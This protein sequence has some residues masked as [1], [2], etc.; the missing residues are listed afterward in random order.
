MTE[1][2]TA[3]RA[4]L[5][6]LGQLRA[7]D[8]PATGGR[9]LAY[10]YDSGLPELDELAAQAMRLVQPVNGLDPTAFPSVATME[11]EVLSFARDTFHGG[12]DVQG[13]VTSG[14][15]ESCLLAV[16]T[17]RDAWRAERERAGQ[18]VE[19]TPRLVLPVTAHAAFQKAAHLFG[20]RL[21]PVPVG[22][23]GQVQARAMIDRL[24]ADVALVVV[25]APSYPT[26]QLDPIRSV[27]AAAKE[28]GIACHVDACI[29]GFALAWWPGL[30]D[31]D[32]RV[33]GVTSLSADLHKYGY[34]PK[35]ASVLLQ[36]GRS[37]HRRQFF[38]TVRWPG[39]P[40][41][42]P[43]LLG[44]KSAAAL[45]AAW[46]ITQRLDADGFR[47]LTAQAQRATEAI[48]HEIGTIAGLRVLGDPTGPLF[49]LVTDTDV[50]VTDRVDPHLLAD[51]MR[52]LGFQ[53]QPQ[54]G[55]AQ[56][57]GVR[58]PHSVH[59]TVT[60]VTESILP[61]FLAVL[62]Q[63]AEDVRGRP[64]PEPRLALAGLR[65]LGLLRPGARLSPDTAWRLLRLMGAGGASGP[66]EM[67]PLLAIV[68]RLPPEVA[69]TILTELIARL[70]QPR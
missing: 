15:T 48:R 69:E 5:D 24:G 3:S 55:L 36:R 26:A 57:S 12:R 7:A 8:V 52:Q 63:A 65:A 22:P 38:A 56:G 62:R 1:L 70:A 11:S 66:Q 6:R 35:G 13:T 45:A 18:P 25:S 50:P 14:G 37:R 19:H 59:L 9:V 47:E 40:V 46:A 23:D 4:V 34:A 16:K 10:V 39:Y 33:P 60:P 51:R 58:V 29:G 61:E 28:L 30:P 53:V 17:A 67:A 31:W 21:D 44:S 2:S 32:F 27:A 68:E 20:L 64:R 42:N 41:V 54:P 43:T 49:A